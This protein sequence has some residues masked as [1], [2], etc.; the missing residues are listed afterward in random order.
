MTI[1][2]QHPRYQGKI[3]PRVECIPCELVYA[4]QVLARVIDACVAESESCATLTAVDEAS[5]WL[6]RQDA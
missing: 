1:C 2:K 5:T 3:A 6:K 4:E